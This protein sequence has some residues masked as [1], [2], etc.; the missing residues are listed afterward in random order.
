MDLIG[1]SDLLSQETIMRS[2]CVRKVNEC[3]ESAD[4]NDGVLEL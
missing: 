3:I 1:Y 2:F 4:A